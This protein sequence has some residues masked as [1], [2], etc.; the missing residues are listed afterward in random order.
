M[1][2][3]MDYD[4]ESD[5][6]KKHPELVATDPATGA[7]VAVEAKARQ[8][9][10]KQPFDVA[11]IRPPIRDLLLNAISKATTLPL[12]VFVEVNLPPE[13]V[14]LPTWV[15]HVKQV[16]DDIAAERGS[17]PFGAVFFT[18]R[19]TCMAYQRNPTRRSTFTPSGRT[20]RR[21]VM[22]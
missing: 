3:Q 13:D 15:P 12:V 14:E 16:A 19:R 4:D 17:S 8:R 20:V 10:Q 21:L 1:G 6:S 2:L 5:G 18:N 11:E 9:M 22:A 7:Q